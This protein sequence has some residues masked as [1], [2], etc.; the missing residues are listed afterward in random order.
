MIKTISGFLEQNTYIITNKQSAI[1]IDAGADISDIASEIDKRNLVLEAVLITHGHYD[2]IRFLPDLIKKYGIKVYIHANEAKLFR[3]TTFNLGYMFGLTLKKINNEDVVAITDG[4]ELIFG[5]I[6][7]RVIH[8]P[9]HTIGSSCFLFENKLFSG[10]TLFKNGVGRCDLPT[11]S[12]LKLH[13]SIQKLCSMLSNNVVIYPGHGD[14][15][16]IKNECF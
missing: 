10:D 11:G 16:T 5:N 12:N 1:V 2:H 4:E 6:K 13:T 3:D 15:T 7:I 9:G 8:T 14:K